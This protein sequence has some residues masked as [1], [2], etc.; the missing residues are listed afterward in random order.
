MK[1]I[2]P[3]YAKHDDVDIEYI[4]VD[5]KNDKGE[6]TS[7]AFDFSEFDNIQKTQCQGDNLIIGG[8][9]KKHAYCLPASQ[10]LHPPIYN[11]VRDGNLIIVGILEIK[12]C[13]KIKNLRT[14]K[15]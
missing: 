6:S 14:F 2:Y 12:F 15:I 1:N 13:V 3:K 4:V 10:I 9:D 7:V 8:V 11:Q 5:E